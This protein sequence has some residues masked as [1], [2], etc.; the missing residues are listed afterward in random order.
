MYVCV[1]K[2]FEFKITGLPL[3][4]FL[5]GVKTHRKWQ[6]LSVGVCLNSMPTS[7]AL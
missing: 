6:S 5:S 3:D 2:P 4:N 1:C 7:K